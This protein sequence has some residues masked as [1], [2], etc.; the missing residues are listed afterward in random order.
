MENTLIPVQFRTPTDNVNKDNA[1][2]DVQE[3]PTYFSNEYGNATLSEN[4]A[5]SYFGSFDFPSVETAGERGDRFHYA[6]GDKS[7]GRDELINSI[8]TGNEDYDRQR[9]STLE[10]ADLSLKRSKLLSQFVQSTSP[11]EL[12]TD[13]INEIRNLDQK[14]IENANKDPKT[15]FERRFA[16][17]ASTDITD[18][19]NDSVES[20]N[21]IKHSIDN[22]NG[23]ITNK[24]IARKLYEDAQDSL[25]D[26]SYGQ[27]AKQFVP[28]YNWLSLRG[29]Y[30]SE[31]TEG[32]ILKSTSLRDQINAAYRLSPDEF[33]HTQTKVINDLKAKDPEL[34]AEY[35]SA[36]L[37]YTSGDTW[38]DNFFN[39]IDLSI[40]TPASVYGAI[41]GTAQL[42]K[43]G[44]RE[45]IRAPGNYISNL[46][47]VQ[48]ADRMNK[49]AADLG[50]SKINYTDLLPEERRL[51]AI[52]VENISRKAAN[53]G[54]F[55]DWQELVNVLQPIH[56]PQSVLEGGTNLTTEQAARLEIGLLRTGRKSL[57][58]LISRPRN[59][60][61][62]STEELAVAA[63]EAENVVKS[64][65][66][67]TTLGSRVA[68]VKAATIE[69]KDLLANTDAI[70]TYIGNN[71]AKGY[72]T[73]GGAKGALTK[74][75]NQLP[76]GSVEKVGD[77]WYIKV[78]DH[79][80]EKSTTLQRFARPNAKAEDKP[81]R[82][83]VHGVASAIRRRDSLIPTQLAEDFKYAQAGTN[84]YFENNRNQ[85]LSDFT[86]LNR[87]SRRDLD[88]FLERERDYRNQPGSPST[89]VRG[90]YSHNVGELNT[91][92]SK[93]MG[94]LPT[95]EETKAYFS[96]KQWNDV[97]Y[98]MRNLDLTR[99]M[100]RL[101]VKGIELK[102]LV[103]GTEGSF[104]TPKLE[105][106]V[107]QAFPWDRKGDAGI[108]IW[109]VNPN[110]ENSVRKNWI[111]DR[112]VEVKEGT[113]PKKAYEK[114][115]RGAGDITREYIDDLVENQGYVVVHLSPW[116]KGD[117]ADF[118]ASH[119]GPGGEHIPPQVSISE[120]TAKN[121]QD[122]S[123]L[124]V[125]YGNT[126]QRFEGARKL[127]NDQLES[128]DKLSYNLSAFTSDA[129][130]KGLDMSIDGIRNEVNRLIERGQLEAFSEETGEAIK[131]LT[132]DLMD[133]DSPDVILKFKKPVKAERTYR[134][135]EFL[136]GLAGKPFSTNAEAIETLQKSRG[137][138][139]YLYG[140]SKNA[141][142]E[143]NPN[144]DFY[145]RVQDLTPEENALFQAHG[146]QSGD[147]DVSL[148][149]FLD[150]GPD[151][152]REFHT[153]P[154][155]PTSEQKATGILNTKIYGSPYVL[156]S[157]AG[158]SLKETGVKNVVV[159][160]P[161]PN[162]IKYLQNQ[163][164]NVNFMTPTQARK[165][166]KDSTT[167]FETPTAAAVTPENR[168]ITGIGNYNIGDEV[169]L[170]GKE[171]KKELA[172]TGRLQAAT[173]KRK[174][175]AL[176][177]DEKYGNAAQLAE[178]GSVKGGSVVPLDQLYNVTTPP[179]ARSV[180]L[181]TRPQPEFAAQTGAYKG[182]EYFRV[183]VE[184]QY[185]ADLQVHAKGKT[186]TI[187]N[188]ISK[189]EATQKLDTS[190]PG[191]NTLGPKV[192]R[193]LF[194]TLAARYPK[195]EEIKMLRVTGARR[196]ASAG[197]EG[198]D[199]Y[200]GKEV[201]IPI[202]RTPR[203]TAAPEIRYEEPTTP[204]A[205]TGTEGKK[206]WE[207]PSYDYLLVRPEHDMR[208]SNI[209]FQRFP[210]K[211]GGHDLD[212]GNHFYVRQ[213]KIYTHSGGRFKKETTTTYEGDN[214]AFGATI[215]SDARE[216]N[217]HLNKIRKILDDDLA[218]GTNN[219]EAYYNR[220]MDGTSGSFADLKKQFKEF[221][222]E[223]HLT[224]KH[225]FVVTPR[226]K[227]T[228]DYIN[229]LQ[230]DQGL[231]LFKN[232]QNHRDSDHNLFYNELN[233][234]FALERSDNVQ[235]VVRRGTRDAPI[236]GTT[237]SGSMSPMS[238]LAN[239]ISQLTRGRIVDD[240]KLKSAE[241]FGKNYASV[242][243][244]PLEKIRRD[245]MSFILN[246]Q[247]KP[248]LK[249]DDLIL[250]NSAKDYR[251]ALIDF[252]GIEDEGREYMMTVQRSLADFLK[253]KLGQP[254][255]DW[256][257][258]H[259]MRSNTITPIRWAN[260]VTFDF[261]FGV[262]NIKQFMV[263]G[264]TSLH[265][266]AR[267]GPKAGYD[268]MAGAHLA[269][270][271]LWNDREDLARWMSKRYQNLTGNKPEHFLE[272]LG[273]LK[274]SGFHI[275]GNETAFEDDFIN[276]SMAP[277]LTTK[278]REKARVF[279]KEGDRFARN[280]A[281]FSAFMNWRKANPTALL[282]PRIEKEILNHADDLSLNMTAASN[283]A[284][285]KGAAAI[286]LKF[287]TY[288][289][290]MAE[291]LM[292]GIGTISAKEKMRAYAFY[293]VLF[294]APITAGGVIGVWPIHKEMAK[295]LQERGYD[296]D[297]NLVAKF[298]NDGL[299][300]TLPHL[301]GL[302]ANISEVIGP[303]GSSWLYDIYNGR[304]EVFDVV[305]G[306][307]GTKLESV[308][309]TAWPFFSLI[310]NVFRTDDN[311]YP[312]SMSDF[313]ALVRT[314]SAGNNYVRVW[315]M[316]NTGQYLT[317][318]RTPLSDN[319]GAMDALSTLFLGT[320]PKA[321]Q[322]AFI[323]SDMTRSTQI[324]KDK[325]QREITRLYRL[326]LKSIANG[327]DEGFL[328]YAKKIRFNIIQN[329]FTA[330]EMNR[331][332]TDAVSQNGDM[333]NYATKKYYSSTPERQ[334]QLIDLMNKGKQ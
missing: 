65:Y 115:V 213:P 157:D 180:T 202:N 326:Q 80:D 201:T 13:K 164:P 293:S 324:Q 251:R 191:A 67:K 21:A 131:Q 62:L 192:I 228:F 85:F 179:E 271:L 286:P 208:L 176:F 233:L 287:T 96:W 249:G 122:S 229:A 255:Y 158:K 124:R 330:N 75:R 193:N 207:I 150:K 328:L 26:R 306:A 42:G 248:G 297:E 45:A 189:Q 54:Q 214:N 268:G 60:E 125:P 87:Q 261:Y 236:F 241:T 237:T 314:P 269:R 41:K 79:V 172:A 288:Y 78:V 90:R 234:Q 8:S 11:S 148:V 205:P 138:A 311:K 145:N 25:K 155:N 133:I 144:A 246:P 153:G 114:R 4:V 162:T 1:F 283:A 28:F 300:E 102:F 30:E 91:N 284:I 68:A 83:W 97:D 321:V 309:E 252:L 73:E 334:Q 89:V 247:W 126:T 308:Y 57:D 103:P 52:A 282:T 223:G 27:A 168:P 167:N 118:M 244:A 19:L 298:F 260:M 121:T 218:N 186:I 188:I 171:D 169:V 327:D 134:E 76:Q 280:T 81:Y 38:R 161:G 289:A 47:L 71:E 221:H 61:R 77:K 34:A 170:V 318:N 15:Y 216:F 264:A 37:G 203:G 130:L 84:A 240:L 281:Y 315:Q 307:G 35:A 163:Y 273:S 210:Y 56:S 231:P 7:P 16:D 296:T 253:R 128:P 182:H 209:G 313:E 48:A 127:L 232:L 151:A 111:P 141:I 95:F 302:D 2:Q 258:R 332:F 18:D 160:R 267:L 142:M 146:I 136:K 139:E 66:A 58:E 276:M 259:L 181:E 154:L 291:Q 290:R 117:L 277:G 72:A 110:T 20:G 242:I 257:E 225:P 43:L 69:A 230:D 331:L 238:T 263:Q 108:L 98:A 198:L 137:R 265:P 275:I 303:S 5:P 175:V 310:A 39:G 132:P 129:T 74:L 29:A 10:K 156:L 220:N 24:A 250:L 174:I 217:E 215:E 112:N 190:L 285:A 320:E 266:M 101:G 107:L 305:V 116:S 92:F 70:A 51:H 49:L 22:F 119:G 63:S 312:L 23:I 212:Q 245:P 196:L 295:I 299:A 50:R 82:S 32:G 149:D 304:S 31:D 109:D 197:K 274:R 64:I 226:D 105:G 178:P 254:N 140:N 88:G 323:M 278:L 152:E 3:Q 204:T 279:F 36:L 224:T 143:P 194:D 177:H 329:G 44:L 46:R 159:N 147:P 100:V 199:K 17:K 165:F 9:Y 200:A 99:D 239:S 222:K 322:K 94:R 187:E 59:L 270:P 235:Q 185:V 135:G 173:D 104:F 123:L 272:A 55:N 40:L 166:I 325:A 14:E 292:P 211:E 317:L 53:S 183:K 227:S 206:G 256:I 33:L 294:G 319:V 6:L 195:A 12:T 301:L 86:G 262:F 184:G 113:A 219:A 106:K 243:N 333:I 316:L 93:E 120:A